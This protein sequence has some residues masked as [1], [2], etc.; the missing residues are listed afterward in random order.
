MRTGVV[1]TLVIVALILTGV[2]MFVLTE[3]GNAMLFRA[4]TAYLQALER[5]LITSGL[6]LAQQK[7]SGGLPIEGPF[8]PN[9]AAFGVPNARLLVRVLEVQSDK[10]RVHIETS[11]RKGRRT[12][13]TSRDYTI[14][15][16]KP[17]QPV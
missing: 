11:C 4:D 9:L 3:G 7:V 2:V 13:D 16:R 1:L 8:E 12:L 5:N 14:L 10:A 17:P 6:A 15:L